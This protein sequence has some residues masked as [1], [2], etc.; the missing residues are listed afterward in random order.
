MKYVKL[1]VISLF[2]FFAVACGVAFSVYRYFNSPIIAE[3]KLFMVSKGDNFHIVL[4][5]LLDSGVVSS[6]SKFIFLNVAKLHRNKN[7]IKA[8]EYLFAK[9]TSLV[10]I[11]EQMERGNVFRRKVT[12]AE[13]L[14]NDTIFKIINGVDGL[15]G[16]LP[17]ME[18]FTE[19]TLLPD[20]YFYS[21]GDEKKD[22]LAK[23]KHEMVDFIDKEWDKRASDLP[24]SS[25]MEALSLAS[26]VEKET[27]LTSE[28]GK[29]AS[30]F[31]NRLRK[32]MRLQSDP[33]VVYAFT[34]GNKELEREIR[35]SDLEAKNIYNTYQIDG[36]PPF[37]IANPGREAIRATLNP[38]KTDYLYFVATG[39][40]GHN[41]S[42]SL[43]E[44]NKFVRAYREKIKKE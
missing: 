28:R 11:L 22:V 36:I 15:V 29:V 1:F 41:F 24:F 33:T 19:G 30:V 27:G 8:G 4:R 38:E 32:K 13:G 5:K 10:G 3:D 34:K 31:V 26:I 37:P 43:A 35:R 44:H 14:T 40:G 25:K 6:E 21:R 20:T 17:P 7:G 2:L 12:I 42:V 23:M 9:G 16:D 18:E 39:N